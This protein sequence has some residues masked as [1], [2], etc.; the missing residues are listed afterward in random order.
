MLL[1]VT[2]DISICFELDSEDG[3][4]FQ[5]FYDFNKM[6]ISWNLLIFSGWYLELLARF[7]HTFKIA[8][9]QKTII[10]GYWEVALVTELKRT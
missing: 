4:Y 6:T 7:I 3:N 10:F 9:N 1:N 5:V 2:T 8:K